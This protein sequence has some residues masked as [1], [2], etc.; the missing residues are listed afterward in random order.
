[1]L[2]LQLKSLQNSFGIV[3]N[4]IDMSEQ[5][6]DMLVLAA[7]TSGDTAVNVALCKILIA[8]KQLTETVFSD[9]FGITNDEKINHAKNI[10]Y[11][12]IE[13]LIQEAIDIHNLKVQQTLASTFCISD[14]DR[15]LEDRFERD[16]DAVRYVESDDHGM[17]P[18][19]FH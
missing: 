14:F 16:E 2:E 12:A 5:E 9:T 13:L 18:S 3:K 17:K 19:D 8:D 1:M 6:K 7:S 10:Y 11:S 15:E 4:I